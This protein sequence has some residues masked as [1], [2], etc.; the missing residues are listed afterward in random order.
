[1]RL[2][3]PTTIWMLSDPATLVVDWLDLKPQSIINSGSLRLCTSQ[4]HG[5]PLRAR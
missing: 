5:T 3:I 4:V 1:M 2:Q